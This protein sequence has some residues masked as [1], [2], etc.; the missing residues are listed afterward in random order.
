MKVLFENKLIGSMFAAPNEN[1]SFPATSLVHQFL[2]YKYKATTFE[3]TITITMPR[4]AAGNSFWFGFSNAVA[5]TV[6]LYSDAL[7]LLETIT[8]DCSRDNGAEYFPEHSNIRVIE[9]EAETSVERDLQ[10]GG[11]A[12]GVAVNMPLPTATFAR[13]IVQ[14]SEND[15]TEDGQVASKYVEPITVYDLPYA[16][17]LRDDFH[18][19][20][21][22]FQRVGRGHVWCD[23]TDEA[24][25]IYKPLYCT[26]NMIDSPARVD[27]RCSFK[28]T[29]TEAR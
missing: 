25:E 12:L 29:F 7:V 14:N 16:G 23:I 18:D 3:D 10:I 28:I 2:R 13:N 26:T 9:I 21:E 4:N 24:H 15:S 8:V 6:R 27:G 5:M 22:Q 17:V 1:T 20:I 11:V 19:I